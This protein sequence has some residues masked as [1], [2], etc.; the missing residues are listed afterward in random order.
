[1]GTNCEGFY[2]AG[3]ASEECATVNDSVKATSGI[4]CSILEAAVVDDLI[5]HLPVCPL[6][7]LIPPG[8]VALAQ[9]ILG[10][11]ATTLHSFCE[12]TVPYSLPLP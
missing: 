9:P 11:G 3:A 1:M 4:G 12:V 5:L 10:L 2:S 8:H 6:Q 7:V